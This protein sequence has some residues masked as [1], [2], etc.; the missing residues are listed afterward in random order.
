MENKKFL[1]IDGLAHF[2]GKL[3]LEF[4]KPSDAP[5]ITRLTKASY[6]ALVDSG[7]VDDDTVYLIVESEEIE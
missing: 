5:K 2:K 4:L 3:D 6:D 7:N 1:D